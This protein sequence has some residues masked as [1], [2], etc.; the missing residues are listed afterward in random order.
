MKLL[1][2]YRFAATEAAIYYL[3]RSYLELSHK[4]LSVPSLDFVY[5]LFVID[6]L[7]HKARLEIALLG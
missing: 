7:I 3:F 6:C 2:D 5:E 1:P 4:V